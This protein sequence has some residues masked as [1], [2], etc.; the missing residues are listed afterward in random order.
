MRLGSRPYISY[1]QKAVHC[2]T[3]AA[4][5]HDPVQV[6]K[7]LFSLGIVRPESTPG[8]GGSEPVQWDG[9]SGGRVLQQTG[10]HDHVIDVCVVH[11]MQGWMGLSGCIFQQP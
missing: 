10:A 9:R 11:W 7:Q 8:L 5:S 1:D 4:H 2:W 3:N 6:P